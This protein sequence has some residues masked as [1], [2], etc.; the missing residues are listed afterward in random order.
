V[1][2]PRNRTLL[3]LL[4]C[5]VCVLVV[6]VFGYFMV[7]KTHQPP[8]VAV[9]PP[10]TAPAAPAPGTSQ[11][12]PVP[13][14]P[15]STAAK[16]PNAGVAAPPGAEARHPVRVL[17]FRAN[18]LGSEYGKLAV[19]PLDALD[20]PVYSKDLACDRV[21]FSN[22]VGICLASDRGV[23]TRYYAVKFDENLKGGWNIPLNGIPSRT[24]V[25]P[26]GRLG[27]ITIFL[28]GHSY[29]SLNFA[30]QTLILDTATGNVL[31]DLE[32]FSVTRDGAPFQSKD[33]NFWG[34]TFAHDENRFYATL[35]SKGQTYLVE[36]NLAEKT[37]K[38]IHQNVECPSLSPDNTRIGFKKRMPGQRILWN[39]H[40]LDLKTMTET[41]LAETRNVDD[42]VEWFDNDHLLY[43]LS[44][45]ETGSSASTDIWMVP[46]NGGGSP[47]ILYKGG[48]SPSVA[49][50][51]MP[52]PPSGAK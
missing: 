7:R 52:A 12:T 43:A 47:S 35:W 48:F 45:S 24:R 8:E 20:H 25:S 9:G 1:N 4:L 14:A 37:A 40:V 42:Q 50:W 26:S 18:A 33:F 28:S 31:A 30:T 39:I 27:S 21:Y 13:G 17:F 3:F 10:S 23:F 49:L 46:A 5:V 22:G 44:E 36:C 29:A 2:Q 51:S 34:V 38:V 16:E 19:A 6:V 41:R 15:S 32:K 11:P